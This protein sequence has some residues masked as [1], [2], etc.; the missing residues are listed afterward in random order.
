M[1]FHYNRFRGLVKYD[2]MRITEEKNL[3]SSSVEQSEL[4]QKK[5]NKQRTAA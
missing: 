2:N 5:L 4:M 3:I 1:Y